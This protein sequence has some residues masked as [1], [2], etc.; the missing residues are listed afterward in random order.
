MFSRSCVQFVTECRHCIWTPSLCPLAWCFGGEGWQG[1]LSGHSHCPLG[2]RASP[3]LYGPQGTERNWN[4]SMCSRSCSLPP[5]S[6]AH[7]PLHSPTS[8]QPPSLLNHPSACNLALSWLV[9]LSSASPT[10]KCA[11][12]LDCGVSSPYLTPWPSAISGD[13]LTCGNSVPG[14]LHCRG[15]MCKRVIAEAV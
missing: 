10:G 2:H 9:T 5:L 11:S 1:E 6:L 7:P 12:C 15:K 3:T 4:P 14:H 8:S 13:H